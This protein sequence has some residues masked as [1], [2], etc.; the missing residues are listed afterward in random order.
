MSVKQDINI[1]STA[2][3][4]DVW[5]SLT[6]EANKAKAI[7]ETRCLSSSETV[8]GKLAIAKFSK[9]KSSFDYKAIA[10]DLGIPADELVSHTKMTPKIAWKDACDE[11]GMSA[12]AKD[13][14][15]TPGTPS[16]KLSVCEVG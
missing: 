6:I 7:I 1:L 5:A 13:A 2:E 3:L 15:K 14:R 9:G 16:V 4:V 10:A 11:F 12:A 8:E